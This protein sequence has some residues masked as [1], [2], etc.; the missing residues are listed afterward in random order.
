[1]LA[2]PNYVGTFDSFAER[3][4]ISPFGHLITGCPK[5]PKLFMSPRPSDWKNDKLH[6][7]IGLKNGKKLKVPAWEI[8]PY[9]ENKKTAFKASDYICHT[10]LAF[11]NLLFT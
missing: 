10:K 6:I 8:I 7:I 5:R 4:I 9:R 1:M 3:F 2:E 11:V